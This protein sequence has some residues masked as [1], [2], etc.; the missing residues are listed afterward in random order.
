MA[1]GRRRTNNIGVVEDGGR[2]ICG[3]EAKRTYFYNKFS[4]TFAPPSLGPELIGGWSNLFGS[5]PFQNP[6]QLSV[7]FTLDEIKKA[8]F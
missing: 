4:D 3:E 2:I 8:T 6:E 1:N 7:P 5:K